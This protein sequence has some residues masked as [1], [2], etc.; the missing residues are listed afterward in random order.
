[1]KITIQFCNPIKVEMTEE[2]VSINKTIRKVQKQNGPTKWA[3]AVN[4]TKKRIANNLRT[5][6]AMLAEDIKEENEL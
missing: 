5:T 1:M 4:R 2:D 6:A 3:V